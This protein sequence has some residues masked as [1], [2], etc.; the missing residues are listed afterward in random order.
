MDDG[1]GEFAFREVLAEPFVVRV[2]WGGEILVI[3]ADLEDDSYEIYERDA[4]SFMQSQ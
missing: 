2:F 3:V 4:I 1:E